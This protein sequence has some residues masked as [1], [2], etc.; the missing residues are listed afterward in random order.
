MNSISV[1]A[2]LAVLLCGRTSTAQPVDGASTLAH[3]PI[4]SITHL[5]VLPMA[6]GRVDFLRNGYALLFKYR[7]QSRMDRGLQSFRI[8]NLLPP[9]TNHS[10]IVQTWNSYEDYL[11]HLAQAH[12]IAFRF[13]VQNNPGLGGVCCVGSP[14]D[15]RQ[16]RQVQS[17]GTPW[18]STDIPR[19]LGPARPLFVVSY[20][21]FQPQANV[22]SGQAQL[23]HYG[24]ATRQGNATGL[25]N[26]TLLRQLDRP[27]RYAI[28]EIWD[29]QKS[30]DAWQKADLTR[31]LLSDLKPLL[32]SPLD[33]RLTAVCGEVFVANVGCTA[34]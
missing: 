10:E 16:Y 33:H 14:I 21:E 27:N 20:V 15:D 19:T 4:Y 7:D 6:T 28:L 23:L 13:D 17:I 29:S 22:E 9:T 25:V 5:D 24:T 11:N 31:T 18:P 32:E 26:F 2:A 34:Q 8:L 1:L 12:T 30:Y 3:T